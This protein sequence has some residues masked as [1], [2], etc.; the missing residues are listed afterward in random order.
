MYHF[1][2]LILKPYIGFFKRLVEPGLLCSL[3]P[4]AC[5]RNQHGADQCEISCS[6]KVIRVWP[7]SQTQ[8][9]H[10]HARTHTR[11]H[12]N[13]HTYR[14]KHVE[15]QTHRNMDDFA[16]FAH[17]LMWTHIHNLLVLVECLLANVLFQIYHLHTRFVLKSCFGLTWWVYQQVERLAGPSTLEVLDRLDV[18]LIKSACGAQHAANTAHF[19]VCV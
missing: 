4:D 16:H 10:T 9:A 12:T 15:L 18:W 7:L 3:G 17:K 19:S 5:S 6:L 2:A 11:T 14:N 1:R 13:T 8:Q